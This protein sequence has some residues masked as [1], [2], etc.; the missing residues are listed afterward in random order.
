VKQIKLFF[1]LSFFSIITASYYNNYSNPP[2]IVSTVCGDLSQVKSYCTAS[3]IN[4]KGSNGQ[5]ALMHS[6]ISNSGDIFVFLME[7]NADFKIKDNFGKTALDYAIEHNRVE[8]IEYLALS[9]ADTN[10]LDVDQVLKDAQKIIKTQEL[11][12]K[13]RKTNPDLDKIKSCIAVNTKGNNGQTALM[14]S[15]ISNSGDIFVFLMENNADFNIKDNFGK[16]ALDYAIEHN[17]VE[18]IEFLALS[19]ADTNGLDVDQIL[20]DAQDAH[21]KIKTQEFITEIK[22]PNPDLNKIRSYIAAGV[23]VNAKDND[24]WT[25][26]TKV[27]RNGHTET[28]QL[29]INVAGADVNIKNDKGRTALMYAAK[30]G[31]TEIAKLLLAAGADVNA[32]GNDGKT[33]LMWAKR[34]NHNEI[35]KLLEQHAKNKAKANSTKKAKIISAK[36]E[37][38]RKNNRG[39]N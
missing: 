8:M 17:R 20:K 5:T 34:A 18:M 23:D 35:V 36:K 13:I 22:K 28:L 30:K 2:I 12:T 32:K 10:G 31:Y 11:I 9:G 16:T 27:L 29:L 38:N 7:N 3:T 37:L 19:G 21:K 15:C 25:A 24:G 26:L 33:A 6:C 14:H 4:A 1:T 39:T